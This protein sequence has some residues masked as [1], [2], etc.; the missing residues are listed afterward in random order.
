MDYNKIRNIAVLK[1]GCS[2]EREVSL[3]SAHECAHA[4]RLLRLMQ[5]KT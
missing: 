1:G 4:L 3:V 2:D 5:I